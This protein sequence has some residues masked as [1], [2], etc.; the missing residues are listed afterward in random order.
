MEGVSSQADVQLARACGVPNTMVGPTGRCALRT[1]GQANK[2]NTKWWTDTCAE[3]RDAPG[4][5]KESWKIQAFVPR[6]RF[7][8]GTQQRE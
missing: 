2:M 3:E 7:K 4:E 6:R 5:D 8:T 1:D